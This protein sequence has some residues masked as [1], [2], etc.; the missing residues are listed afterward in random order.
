MLKKK[1]E[2]LS[3][4]MKDYL[5]M[6]QKNTSGL[7]S[8]GNHFAQNITKDVPGRVLSAPIPEMYSNK[9]QAN[10]NDYNIQGTNN[11]TGYYARFSPAPIP[12]KAQSPMVLS[13]STPRYNQE[14]NL[15]D[16]F[17]YRNQTYEQAPIAEL[18]S[19]SPSEEENEFQKSPQP[20]R[21]PY[22]MNRNDYQEEPEYDH[23]VE[24]V[25]QRDY[26]SSSHHTGPSENRRKL[27]VAE[28]RNN[29]NQISPNHIQPQP[30]QQ[31]NQM[32]SGYQQ[33]LGFDSV[34][35]IIP[36]KVQ[37]PT[38]NQTQ[39][40]LNPNGSNNNAYFQDDPD[41]Y[42][43][44]FDSPGRQDS[45][46]R[47]NNYDE[48]Q[49]SPQH[50]PQ[51]QPSQQA[52]PK[53]KPAQNSNQLPQKSSNAYNYPKIDPQYD[54]YQAQY[55]SSSSKPA[56][57]TGASNS[58]Q[59]DGKKGGGRPKKNTKQTSQAYV[60]KQVDE[61]IENDHEPY[62]TGHYQNNKK[63]FGGEYEK[64]Y[65]NSIVEKCKDWNKQIGSRNLQ[66]MLNENDKEVSSAIIKELTPGLLEISLNIFG[67][68]VAQKMIEVG[69]NRFYKASPQSLAMIMKKVASEFET[70]CYNSYGCRV[71]LKLYEIMAV[72]DEE[73]IENLADGF[74]EKN[75]E[76][77]VE[78][79][80]ANYI[81]QKV[82]HLQPISKLKFIS[83]IFLNDV[84]EE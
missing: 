47:S 46:N 27:A 37:H 70:Y 78:D 55:Y 74:I 20:Q 50:Y 41:D 45:Y 76:K 14:V 79:Q 43:D 82:I 83:N 68:Y 26:K 25:E 21:P 5:D 58:H 28:F 12:P 73:L 56:N 17:Y 69:K 32:N 39:G 15:P 6:F 1:M 59:T 71:I 31:P 2:R 40:N 84:T 22:L 19:G 75:V 13:T 62:S 80:N 44:H 24:Y 7:Q 67:N 49:Y 34:H 30:Y 64:E 18:E 9:M 10:Y 72:T 4:R 3:V 8:T 33:N 51:E 65:R 42:E 77:M 29:R 11:P 57:K 48:R 61:E 53:K 52:K 63:K 36:L 81:I 38:Y 35:N 54:K 23:R 16:Q 66:S 60:W